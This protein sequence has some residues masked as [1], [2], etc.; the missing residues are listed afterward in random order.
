MK[1]SLI[2]LMLILALL[3]SFISCGEYNPPSNSNGQNA[4]S[5]TDNGS[6]GGEQNGSQNNTGATFTAAV[7]ACIHL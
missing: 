6:T 2:S 7:M 4:P 3:V 5:D 1:K